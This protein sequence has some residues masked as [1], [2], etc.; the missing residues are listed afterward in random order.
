MESC[1]HEKSMQVG[2]Q[3]ICEDCFLVLGEKTVPLTFTPA[4]LSFT[5]INVPEITSGVF[6]DNVRK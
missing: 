2:S 1:K 6:N 5:Y 4:I 3:L